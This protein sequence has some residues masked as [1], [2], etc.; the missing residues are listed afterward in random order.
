[1]VLSSCTAATASSFVRAFGS[2][3]EMR[4]A[5]VRCMIVLPAAS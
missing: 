3:D 1:V 2:P 4:K 5:R